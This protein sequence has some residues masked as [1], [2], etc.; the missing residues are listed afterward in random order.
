MA[1]PITFRHARS[2]VSRRWLAILTLSGLMGWI[3][4]VNTYGAMLELD[5]YLERAA[6]SRKRGDWQSVASQL[7]Q[8]LNHPHLP[9]SGMER[10]TLHLDYGRALG[11]LC[12]YDE[13]E[14]YMLLARDIARAG[15]SSAAEALTE[16][17]AMNL[18][19]GR[20]DAAQ[21]YSREATSPGA[22]PSG[23]TSSTTPYGTRCA[24]R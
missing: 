19:R 12:R 2:L 9:S 14:K 23:T 20:A 8:A 16:L 7:A 15:G 17:A 4:C 3:L 13:A 6:A 11:V 24:K 1:S 18:A 21:Q 22:L 5:E 10:S